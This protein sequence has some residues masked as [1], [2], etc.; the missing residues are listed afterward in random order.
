MIQTQNNAKYVDLV[1][2]NEIT[3][4][5]FINTLNEKKYDQL[6]DP[7][8]IFNIKNHTN[9]SN[10]YTCFDWAQIEHKT[11]QLEVTC[12]YKTKL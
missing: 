12:F 10:V 8:S 2:K 7:P 9:D 1:W 6:K 5:Y 11:K 4:H 3:K